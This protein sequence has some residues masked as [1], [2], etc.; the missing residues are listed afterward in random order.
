MNV[1][2]AHE[3]TLARVVPYLAKRR[4]LA[5]SRIVD[6][7]PD[8]R[9]QVREYTRRNRNYKV[10]PA[11][12]APGLLVKQAMEP[13]PEFRDGLE[14]E[15]RILRSIARA[16]ALRALRAWTPRFVAYDRGSSVLVTRLVHPATTLLRLQQG[17][18]GPRL[19]PEAAVTVA[20]F[21][22]AVHAARP[23]GL[24]RGEPPLWSVPPALERRAPAEP[25]VAD[26]L[27][28]MRDAPFRQELG[29]L[30]RAWA[31]G[32]SLVHTD[33]RMENFLLT[34]G[35]GPRGALA[36]RLV[37]WELARV[38]DAS[39]DVAYALVDLLRFCLMERLTFERAHES[40][41]ALVRAYAPANQRGRLRARVAAQVPHVLALVAYEALPLAHARP[42]VMREA[43][44]MAEA[45]D[46]DAWWGSRAWT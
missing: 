33:P 31:R 23:A 19:V 28:W 15:A 42:D 40:A 18:T 22:R 46:L 17:G 21:L 16:P 12:G 35:R 30:R 3:L 37:D 4:L 24:P 29:E 6:G 43:R 8:G 44:R 38:G 26:L 13:T 11:G 9:L 7:T 5:T 1:V 45:P 39:W 34:H 36:V 2:P 32:R 25:D 20:R 14:R 41:A 10:I 27:A